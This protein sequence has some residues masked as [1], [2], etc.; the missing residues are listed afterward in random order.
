MSHSEQARKILRTVQDECVKY[1]DFIDDV[2]HDVVVLCPIAENVDSWPHRR[3]C[4]MISY[5]VDKDA[6]R[7]VHSQFAAKLK[8]IDECDVPGAIGGIIKE[9]SAP[10][11]DL[12]LYYRI[13]FKSLVRRGKLAGKLI[14]RRFKN[15]FERRNLTRTLFVDIRF[16][17]G[18]IIIPVALSVN[19][20]A[21]G[22][23]LGMG[24]ESLERFKQLQT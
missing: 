23:L 7:H 4:S 24:F 21:T 20:R 14:M 15:V 18:D 2:F 10:D 8:C 12:S 13:I 3:E 6:T 11:I 1:V 9:Y 19:D 5:P 16:E 17:N 22:R